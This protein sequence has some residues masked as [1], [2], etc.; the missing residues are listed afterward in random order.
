M[1][2]DLEYLLSL[3]FVHHQTIEF[4]FAHVASNHGNKPCLT[5]EQPESQATERSRRLQ[6][7]WAYPHIFLWLFYDPIKQTSFVTPYKKSL[8]PESRRLVF[9]NNK[10]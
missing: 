1:T 10:Q 8:E 3:A 7:Y 2:Y 9:K 4:E 6:P 5:Q